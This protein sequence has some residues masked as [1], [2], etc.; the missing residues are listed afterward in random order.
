MV[1]YNLLSYRELLSGHIKKEDE[2]LYPWFD[3]NLTTRQIGEISSRFFD[4]ESRIGNV[5]TNEFETFLN[6]NEAI[7][8]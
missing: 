7:F 8:N 5:L 6:E 4:V 1:I 3:R 2:I